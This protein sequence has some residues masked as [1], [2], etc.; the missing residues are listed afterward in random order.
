M[1]TLKAVTAADR[2]ALERRFDLDHRLRS[3]ASYAALLERILGFYRPIEERLAPFAEPLAGVRYADRRKAPLLVADLH[4]LGVADRGSRL[5]E[6]EVLPAVRS[7]EEAIGVLYVLEAATLG[8]EV[9]ARRARVRLGV[10]AQ[11]GGSFFRA[12]GPAVGARWRA[13]GAAVETLSDGV[14]TP[15]TCAAAMASYSGLEAWLCDDQR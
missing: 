1:A 15:A 13:F 5:P 7:P 6:A 11:T 10:T 2:D 3:R 9:I 12:Y 8:G 14:P 4:A